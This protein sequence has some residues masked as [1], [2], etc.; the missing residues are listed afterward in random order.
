[1]HIAHAQLFLF[2]IRFKDSAKF[3]LKLEYISTDFHQATLSYIKIYQ[4][5]QNIRKAVPDIHSLLASC[6]FISILPGNAFRPISDQV[7]NRISSSN[8]KWGNY[9]RLIMVTMTMMMVMIMVTMMMMMMM[10]GAHVLEANPK[11][12]SFCHNFGRGAS[13]HPFSQEA[14]FG[15]WS[16]RLWMVIQL[17]MVNMV[18]IMMMEDE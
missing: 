16:L 17:I 12:L 13:L 7:W 14:I 6:H 5:G 11:T 9:N 3:I 2:Q 8:P 1:M 15:H 4:S 18:L 10:I